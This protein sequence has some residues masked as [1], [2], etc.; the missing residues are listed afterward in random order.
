MVGAGST[1]GRK[2]R[3]SAGDARRHSRKQVIWGMSATILSR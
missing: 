1:K 2:M 3:F